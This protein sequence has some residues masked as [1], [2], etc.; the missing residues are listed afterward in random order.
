MIIIIIDRTEIEEEPGGKERNSRNEDVEWKL[1]N[2]ERSTYIIVY[3][4]DTRS[5]GTLDIAE[6]LINN[7]M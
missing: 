5:I 4:I 3:I 6:S 1:L 7:V 2:I